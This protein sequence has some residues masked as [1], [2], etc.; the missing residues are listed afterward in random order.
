VGITQAGGN[1]GDTI[2]ISPTRR[3]GLR[4]YETFAGTTE[5]PRRVRQLD[6][7]FLFRHERIVAHPEVTPFWS[8]F[9]IAGHSSRARSAAFASLVAE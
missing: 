8:Y 1:S 4:R 9:R 5:G 3:L 6:G 7:A 2:S